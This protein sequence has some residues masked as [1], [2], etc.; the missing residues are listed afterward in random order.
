MHRIQSTERLR[1]SS[2]RKWHQLADVAAADFQQRLGATRYLRLGQRDRVRIAR[3]LREA[4]DSAFEVAPEHVARIAA[5][6]DHL[7]D[8]TERSDAFAAA[9]ARTRE[10]ARRTAAIG[11]V[12]TLPAAVPG[13]GTAMAALGLVADWRYVAEEQRDLILEVS[14]ILGVPL[15][16]PTVAVRS[17]FVAGAAAGFG[18]RATGPEI[19][20]VLAEHVARRSVA[21][22]V[23]GAGAVAASALNYIETVNVGRVAIQRLARRSGIETRPLLPPQPHSELPQLEQ[24]II[25][26]IKAALAGIE[27]ERP[28][29]STEQRA[30]LA[31]LTLSERESLFDLAI[32]SSASQGGVSAEE[33][34]VL[35]HI[36]DVL[37]FAAEDLLG[38]ISE[39]QHE[40]TTF[41]VRFRRLLDSGRD[42]PTGV[43][44]L[45]WRRTRALSRGHEVEIGR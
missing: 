2:D 14:A 3:R 38:T 16:E 5:G 37:G 43:T 18:E 9:W 41:G 44:R 11:A 17:F 10:R 30:V 32:V 40:V 29:F 15:R 35:A 33:Q 21:R 27:V 26:A 24:T 19:V 23:P 8:E 42:T 36:A 34:R 12:T 7:R 45:I 4:I 39:A 20:H 6:V 31:Q 25:E 28:L 22:V 13:L 1:H